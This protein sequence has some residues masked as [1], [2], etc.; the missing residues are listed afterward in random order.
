MGQLQ[1]RM[2]QDL[3]LRRS[4][5]TPKRSHE[6]LIALTRTN[7]LNRDPESSNRMDRAPDPNPEGLDR[8]P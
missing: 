5:P 4:S 7:L 3:K 2:A 8:H 6:R 1:D